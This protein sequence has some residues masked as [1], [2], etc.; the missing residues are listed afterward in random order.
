MTFVHDYTRFTRIFPLAA[1]SEVTS[2]FKRFFVFIERQFDTRIKAIQSD[3]GGEFR[4]LKP[5]LEAL[6]VV[7]RH[8]CPH[9]H[10][11]NGKVER[12]HM[13][14]TKLGLTLL[15]K[16]SIP[17]CF[18]WDAFTKATYLINRLPT[19]SLQHKSPYYSLYKT[20][21]DYTF[22][23]TFGCACFPYL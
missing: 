10:Q 11:Q 14:I 21:P 6:G 23:K 2:V 20:Q 18:W 4:P 12:K 9:T 3:W 5:V 7:F 13:H 22:L 1:K 19:P 16:A 17:Q 15:A 8:P